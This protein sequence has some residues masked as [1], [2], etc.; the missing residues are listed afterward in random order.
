[1]SLVAGCDGG[2]Y[3]IA[4]NGT[5]TTGGKE[6]QW[7]QAFHLQQASN[8]LPTRGWR[9]W[10]RDSGG[11]ATLMDP[12]FRWTGTAAVADGGW[13]DPYPLVL[14]NSRRNPQTGGDTHG[15]TYWSKAD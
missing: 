8:G 2:V 9:A 3:V 11:L 10:Q 13:N 1:M 7:F 15:Q 12:F 6:Y 4:M 14:L 5:S